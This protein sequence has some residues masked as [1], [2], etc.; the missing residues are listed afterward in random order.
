MLVM[1]SWIMLTTFE[2]R[3]Q[4]EF[5]VRLS[6]FVHSATMHAPVISGYTTHLTR[7][8][9]VA[10]PTSYTLHER[11]HTQ[12]PVNRSMP[13]CTATHTHLP[14]VG[15]TPQANANLLNLP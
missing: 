1:Y 11:S 13:S 4:I 7:T 8:H 9:R 6:P 5:F 3:I 12:P 14:A 15:W 10:H 2:I